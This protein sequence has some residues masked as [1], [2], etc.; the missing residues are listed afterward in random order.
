M[1]LVNSIVSK[2]ITANPIQIHNNSGVA[3]DEST[4]FSCG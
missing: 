4:G 2:R 3:N 1:M